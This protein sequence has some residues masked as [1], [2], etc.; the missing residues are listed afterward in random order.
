MKLK[1]RIARPQHSR[2]AA[3][4]PVVTVAA[5]PS[6]EAC[7]KCGGSGV[8]IAYTGRIVGHCFRCRGSGIEGGH[9]VAVSRWDGL[10]AKI[11]M[12]PPWMLFAWLAATAVLYAY[13]GHL[14]LFIAGVVIVVRCWYWL[15]L[16]FPWTMTFV[17]FF[18]GALLSGGRGRGDYRGRY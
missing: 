9:A 13:F 5:P 12:T 8:F 1:T 18:I 11:R 3:A 6:A 2:R 14:I 15:S 4:I 10:A 16:R 7:H 17:N